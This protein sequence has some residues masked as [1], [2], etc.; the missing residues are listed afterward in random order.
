QRLASQ[1][2]VRIRGLAVCAQHVALLEQGGDGARLVDR[3]PFGG[4]QQHVGEARVGG[5][6][7]DG[8]TVRRDAT[9]VIDR[10]ELAQQLLR[11]C[12]RAGRRRI[13]PGK[14]V[15]VRRAPCGKL[16]GE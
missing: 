7:R 16:E 10:A 3:P 5:Q 12:K 1:Q 6:P 14:L 11:L 8:T 2:Q 15:R 9:L 4:V 13:E